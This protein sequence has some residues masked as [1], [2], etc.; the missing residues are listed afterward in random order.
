MSEENDLPDKIEVTTSDSTFRSFD[1][2][3]DQDYRKVKDLQIECHSI[4]EE[5]DK[6]VG[7]IRGLYFEGTQM[8]SIEMRADHDPGVELPKKINDLLNGVTV[9]LVE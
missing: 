1:P 8:G 2:L 7:A 5:N 6:P 9:E 4:L 3:N